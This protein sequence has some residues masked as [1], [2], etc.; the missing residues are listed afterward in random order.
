MKTAFLHGDLDEEIYINLPE[1]Y[2]EFLEK[3][4]GETTNGRYLSLEKGLYGLVQAVHQWFLKLT[5]KLKNEMGVE[6]F[7][8]DSCLFKQSNK[9]GTTFLIIYVDDCLAIGD[10]TA[11]KMLFKEIEEDFKTTRSESIEDSI[12]CKIE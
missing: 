9:D 10:K 1:G 2:K 11:V 6:Q 8:N 4:F 3:E 12:G 5:N 7:N